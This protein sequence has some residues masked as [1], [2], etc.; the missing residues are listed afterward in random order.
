MSYEHGTWRAIIEVKPA[1][2][3]QRFKLNK[4]TIFN[5]AL[6]VLTASLT[7]E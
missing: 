5:F 2:T 4:Q 7:D 6:G 3:P 1:L